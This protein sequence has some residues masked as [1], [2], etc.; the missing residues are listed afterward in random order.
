MQNENPGKSKKQPNNI[1]K[2]LSE[3]IVYIARILFDN[4]LKMQIRPKKSAFI[5]DL[6][7]HYTK[8]TRSALQGTYTLLSETMKMLMLKSS[9]AEKQA[10]PR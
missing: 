9:A 7:L 10:R 6:F 5:P 1:K 4:L 2:L 8:I 3:K